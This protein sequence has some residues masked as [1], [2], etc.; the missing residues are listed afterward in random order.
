MAGKDSSNSKEDTVI[1]SEQSVG[2]RITDAKTFRKLIEV[3][4]NRSEICMQSETS[5]QGPGNRRFLRR[6]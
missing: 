3:F 5:T 4:E 2:S 1:Y 6:V